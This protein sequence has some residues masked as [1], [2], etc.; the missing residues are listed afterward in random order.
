MNS[1]LGIWKYFGLRLKML[2]MPSTIIP[3][4]KLPH[5]VEKVELDLY[6]Y[7]MDIEENAPDVKN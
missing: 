3:C 2:H 1:R 5:S 6:L 7:I 4:L